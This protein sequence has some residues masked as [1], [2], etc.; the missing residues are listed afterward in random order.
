MLPKTRRKKKNEEPPHSQT[1]TKNNNKIN[2]H[3][4]KMN[5]FVTFFVAI[6]LILCGFGS[7]FFPG[8]AP[9]THRASPPS[10]ASASGSLGLCTTASLNSPRLRASAGHFSVSS[11]VNHARD[12]LFRNIVRSESSSSLFAKKKRP[13]TPRKEKVKK[14]KDDV[15]EVEGIVQESLPNAMFRVKIENMD[16]VVLATI[17]GKIRKNFV[18]I[19]VGDTVTMELS[20]YDLTRGAWARDD[21]RD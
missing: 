19:L 10:C 11:R 2:I 3:N 4:I 16:T 21:D 5:K 20:P 12:H 15:I 1:A 9:S 17:S 7:A 13:D 6:S 18:R 14:P 8:S